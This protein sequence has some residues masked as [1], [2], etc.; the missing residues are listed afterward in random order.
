MATGDYLKTAAAS[1][2]NAAVNLQQQAKEMQANLIRLKSDN[3]S[4]ID[5]NK[6]EIKNKQVEV[7]VISDANYKSRLSVEIQKL[8]NE[9]IAAEQ[10]LRQAEAD[11]NNAV[12]AKLDSA[13][14]IEQQAKQLE[15]QAGTLD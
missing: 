12:K 4:V 11:V 2:R 9:I 13:T 8:Q 10:Q 7:D 5:K 15:S 1:L 14:G 6:I 3:N